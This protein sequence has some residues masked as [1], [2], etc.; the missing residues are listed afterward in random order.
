MQ[1]VAQQAD[2]HSDVI[3]KTA[4]NP[5]ADV[6]AIVPNGQL[7]VLLDDNGADCVK[8]RWRDKEGFAKRANV[9]KAFVAP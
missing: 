1:V 8:V 3:L 4:P 6:V 7:M 9:V 5:Q 2:G